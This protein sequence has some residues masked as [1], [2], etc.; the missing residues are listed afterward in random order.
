MARAVKRRRPRVDLLAHDRLE[1]LRLALS[2]QIWFTEDAGGKA[3]LRRQ[4]RYID[5]ILGRD[6]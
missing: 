2:A 4:I 3:N 5:A 1:A 6:T